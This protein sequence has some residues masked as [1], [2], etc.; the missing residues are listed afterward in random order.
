MPPF[1]APAPYGQENKQLERR[2]YDSQDEVRQLE[3]TKR[4]LEEA[5]KK[6]EDE[7]RRCEQKI[8]NLED[9]LY[10]LSKEKEVLE[11]KVSTLSVA[12]TSSGLNDST[13]TTAPNTEDLF[14]SLH[15]A[16]ILV[17]ALL[18]AVLLPG[19][20]YME[21]DNS[22]SMEDCEEFQ[23]ATRRLIKLAASESEALCIIDLCSE[24]NIL[25]ESL[26]KTVKAD[27]AEK[28]RLGNE[29]SVLGKELKVNRKVALHHTL[30]PAQAVNEEII[31]ITADRDSLLNEQQE[32][33]DMADLLKKE[34]EE[35]AAE[36]QS[37]QHVADQQRI[38]IS[39]HPLFKV[40]LALLAGV[41]SL[42]LAMAKYYKSCSRVDYRQLERATGMLMYL[43][44][45]EHE[46]LWLG[47]DLAGKLTAELMEAE[48]NRSVV[49]VADQ[50]TITTLTN[51][52]EQLQK[53]LH[54]TCN[55]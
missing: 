10:Y 28:S 43:Y 35:M 41:L 22:V 34:R 24:E 52:N 45:R 3:S 36:L 29:I 12:N 4:L 1:Y 17:L 9:K 14:S 32:L 37:D 15:P 11:E 13:T 33:L 30:L 31:S 51:Q 47:M 54:S 53:E 25:I 7:K 20:V 8:G 16:F 48:K 40:L 5:K 39:I 23:E 42:G 18:V 19:L 38:T 55:K 49:N 26:E 44:E 27:E 21:M 50:Q 46:R 6:S 2:L